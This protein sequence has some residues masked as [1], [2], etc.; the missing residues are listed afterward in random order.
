MSSYDIRANALAFAVNHGQGK[1]AKEIVLNANEFLAFLEATPCAPTSETPSTPSA[2]PTAPKPRKKA[3]PA[4]QPSES[5]APAATSTITE[6][7][8]TSPTPPVSASEPTAAAPAPSSTT[9]AA[10]LTLDDVRRALTKLQSAKDRATAKAI[11]EQ[12]SKTGT[13]GGLAESDYE[14]LI[15]HCAKA[16]KA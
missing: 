16:E 8:P 3:T 9:K 4:A 7:S 11:L 14:P 1:S 5:T 13:V 15:S 10:K 12:Y 2:T 6:Y